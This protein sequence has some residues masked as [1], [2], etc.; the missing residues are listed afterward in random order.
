[1]S[2]QQDRFG[3]SR[4]SWVPQP[5]AGEL[6]SYGVAVLLIA[7]SLLI[8]WILNGW[9]AGNVPYLQFFPAILVAAW[10]GGL[11]PGILATVLSALAAMYLFLPPAGL[12]VGDAADAMSL[13]LFV[14]IGSGIAWLNHQLRNA[15]MVSASRAERLDAI[16]NTTVDGII[17]ISA[18]GKIEAFNRGAERLFGYPE[19]EVIGR[20]V[21]L[22]M[23]SPYHEEHDGYLK[24]YL[25][26]GEA[27]IIGTGREVTGRRRDG[28]VF[29]LHLS[30]GEMQVGGQ[31]KFTGMLHDLTE[32]VQLQG[33]LG[34]SEAR[35]Q[36]VIDSAVDGI[37]VID[38]HGRI[39]GFNP[40]AER[41]FGY[42]AE[43]VF[44]R[45][46]DM[47]MPSPYREEHDT[48]LSR[49]LATGRAKIIGIGREVQGL[50]K[51]GTTFP[52]H[53]SVGQI[54][55]GSERKFTGI[56]HDLTSRVQLEGQ[57]REQAALAKLG[58]MA[59]V[60]AH[61]VKNPLAGIRGAIQVFGNRMN[62]DGRN[63]QVLKEIVTRID[64]LDQM[65]K[66]L[67]LF[68]RPPKP[69]RAP[70][71]LVPL[72]TTTASLLNQDPAWHDVDVEVDGT[73]P[74]I[75][76]DADM[77]RIV[78]QNLLINGAHAMH[79]KGRIRVSV[80]TIDSSCQITF[81]DGGPGIP[82]DIREKIFT[83]FFTTKTRGS[84]LGLPTAKR[85]IEAHN[86]QIAID[87]PP[88][89]GTTVVVRLPMGTA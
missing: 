22:L 35:W 45:N 86:G 32:R 85:F 15:A 3:G 54:M 9:F 74:P 11:G 14:V 26:T 6:R 68:A 36:A 47:L 34:S 39:E 69:K 7:T 25:T 46:V 24:R 59:A 1:M 50:R 30:V 79:G 4:R 12:A 2:T 29:P 42:T 53:L 52:L 21:S 76:A 44:G 60:I 18:D 8:R 48:Y 81:I 31:R 5:T 89:G 28:T 55:V 49:Y 33:R 82:A 40:A 80:D 87:C 37:I 71:D 13:G 65:M 23:P 27:K 38:A 63:G 10:Y 16:I 57:L 78:F 62:Q 70:I 73:A 75:S 67:L 19:S 20:N 72:V 41:L 17:V 66:D 58:E 88:A 51:D 64:A 77:L 84:G 61:E 56:L 83:P 43:E